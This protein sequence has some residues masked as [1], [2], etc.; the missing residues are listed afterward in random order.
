M[1]LVVMCAGASLSFYSEGHT[2]AL[3]FYSREAERVAMATGFGR[4]FSSGITGVYFPGL[5]CRAYRGEGG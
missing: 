5:R 1:E 3:R 4:W 2:N